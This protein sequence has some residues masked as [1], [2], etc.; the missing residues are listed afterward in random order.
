MPLKVPIEGSETSVTL[1]FELQVISSHLQQSMAFSRKLMRPLSCESS[2]TNLSKELLSCSVHEVARV[3]KER[4]IT[5]AG[6]NGGMANA[7]ILLLHA[8]RV[9][10]ICIL[11]LDVIST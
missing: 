7:L 6:P 4:S 5:R 10:C 2:V 8:E 1:L 11:S 3:A 9:S